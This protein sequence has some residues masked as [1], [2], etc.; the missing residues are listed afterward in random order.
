METERKPEGNE[1]RVAAE[2][3]RVSICIIFFSNGKD[4]RFFNHARK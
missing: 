1:R 2:K 3:W 4:G